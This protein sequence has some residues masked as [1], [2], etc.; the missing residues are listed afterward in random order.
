[1]PVIRWPCRSRGLR[2]HRFRR[3]SRPQMCLGDVC[4]PVA[5]TEHG[6]AGAVRQPV[7][8]GLHLSDA[9]ALVNHLFNRRS[10][11]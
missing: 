9:L 3:L 7:E 2:L 5:K 6:H 4:N 8:E 11:P 10:P 1:M